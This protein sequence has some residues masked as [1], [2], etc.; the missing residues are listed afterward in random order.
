[1]GPRNKY[2]PV[3]A[4]VDNRKVVLL[5][6]VTENVAKFLQRRYK[7]QY[8]NN[9]LQA[10]QFLEDEDSSNIPRYLCWLVTCL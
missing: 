9:I 1:M 5:S 4:Q 7:N 10:P 3:G 8:T 2:N 6:L